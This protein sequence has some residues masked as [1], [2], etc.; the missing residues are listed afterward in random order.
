MSDNK[1]NGGC[2]VGII[3]LVVVAYAVYVL[4]SLG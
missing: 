3:S 1:Q 4:I 2:L